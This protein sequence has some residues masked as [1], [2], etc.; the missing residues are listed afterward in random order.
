[1]QSNTYHMEKLRSLLVNMPDLVK[2]L[3][4]I[5]YGKVSP[6]SNR[7]W[8]CGNGK[9]RLIAQAQPTEVAAILVNLQRIGDEF[10]TISTLPFRS[11][12][13]NNIVKLLPTIRETSQSFLN[14]IDLKAAKA[15]EEAN[16]W[17]DPDKFPDLQDAKDVSSKRW[18]G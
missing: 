15:N 10:K 18:S 5:Q 7:Y 16:L 3:T 6:I 2:G 14:D 1:M 8:F 4:R 17:S 9:L 12:L 11:L 13:L